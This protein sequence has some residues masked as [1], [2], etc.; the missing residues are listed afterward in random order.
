MQTK[1][2]E[3]EFCGAGSKPSGANLTDMIRTSVLGASGFI[4]SA[5]LQ[6]YRTRWPE[7]LGTS[8]KEQVG[9]SYFDFAQPKFD[10]DRF[11][12]EGY[13]AV[14]LAG[15][16]PLIG[17]CE[18]NPAETRAVNVTGVL[19]V[20]RQLAGSPIQV[21]WFS[22]DYVFDG[23]TGG[24]L[25]DSPV[26]PLTEYGRQKAE[27]EEKLPL[28]CPNSLVLRLSKTYSGVSGDL[29]LLSEMARDL[30]AGKRLRVARDQVFSPTDVRDVVEVV[31][32][33]Q[34]R[35]ARGLYNLAAPHAWSRLKIAQ[36][37]ARTLLLDSDNIEA[38]NLHDLPGMENRPLNT[39][40][41]SHRLERELPQF[42]FRSLESNLAGMFQ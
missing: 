30:R 26:H 8:R 28:L 21:V 24:Y 5:F 35:G 27:V 39:S 36:A 42:E 33:L 40:L 14:L 31:L 41:V 23:V 3:I 17:D 7:C 13:A 9:L 19:E 20:A 16:R 1:A 38:M 11:I 4:G 32:G 10:W 34:E 2:H 18:R 12:A 29:T 25:D 6:A 37:V 15:A 22:S